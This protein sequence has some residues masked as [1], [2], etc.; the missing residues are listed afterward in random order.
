MT[1]DTKCTLDTNSCPESTFCPA[2]TSAPARCLLCTENLIA[3]GQGCNCTSEL[4]T[5][6]CKQCAAQT[7]SECLPGYT[8]KT[9]LCEPKSPET[10]ATS[11]ECRDAG[12]GYCDEATR[13]CLPCQAGCAVCTSPTFCA[14]CT[15]ARNVTNSDGTCT[16]PCRQFVTS[17]FCR[18]GSPDFCSKNITSPCDC[19]GAAHCSTCAYAKK[20][21]CASCLQNR[22]LSAEGDC[23][24]CAEGFQAVG[25]LC[26]ERERVYSGE[27]V[28]GGKGGKGV[29]IGAIIAIIAVVAIIAVCV[30]LGCGFAAKAYR[31][32]QKSIKDGAERCGAERSETGVEAAVHIA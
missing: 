22:S 25:A 27:V 28:E 15:G 17:S 18:N 10:C 2:T 5:R 19:D 31:K 4:A 8:L 23:G 12:S 24:A 30:I 11:Q 7:C 13:K 16:L 29:S 1:H 21:R 6:N 20:W 9:G 3:Y 14:A 32:R 26:V